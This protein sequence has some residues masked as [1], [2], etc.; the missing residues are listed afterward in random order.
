MTFG[1]NFRP[2]EE[3]VFKFDYQFNLEDWERDEV[4]NDAVLVSVASY[5]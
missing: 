1:L 2:I 4:K 3:T 5:F